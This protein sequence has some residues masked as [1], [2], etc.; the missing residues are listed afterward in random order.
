MKLP[1]LVTATLFTASTA[2]AAPVVYDCKFNA[3]QTRGWISE[4]A[5]YSVD[6]D[7]K[8]AVAFD[9]HIKHYMEKPI[10]AEYKKRANGMIRL[11]WQIEQSANDVWNKTKRSIKSTY[12]VELKPDGSSASVRVSFR[13]VHQYE[14]AHANGKCSVKK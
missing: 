1:L 2:L 14:N 11:R 5:F 7:A 8:A 4:R 10:P 3:V 6:A 13:G 9:S 12:T